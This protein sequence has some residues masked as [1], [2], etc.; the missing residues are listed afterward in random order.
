MNKQ[1]PPYLVLLLLM[2]SLEFLVTILSFVIAFYV[3][4]MIIN[5]DLLLNITDWMHSDIC[6]KNPVTKSVG[7]L[8]IGDPQMIPSNVSY[9]IYSWHLFSDVSFLS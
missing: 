6:V 1:I 7:F 9:L 8:K 3:N 2:L 4:I 5:I